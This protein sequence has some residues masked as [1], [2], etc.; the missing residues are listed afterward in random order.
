MARTSGRISRIRSVSTS[1]AW[2]RPPR[3]KG[4]G[5]EAHDVHVGF[6]DDEVVLG[7]GIDD[8][9]QAFS[10]VKAGDSVGCLT[11]CPGRREREDKKESP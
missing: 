6:L 11:V 2:G 7:I 10:R 9:G 5:D 3:G 8:K 1:Y 4:G